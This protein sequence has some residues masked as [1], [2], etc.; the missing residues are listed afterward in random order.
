[1]GGNC[2]RGALGRQADG[3]AWLFKKNIKT[4]ETFK[5]EDDGRKVI[6]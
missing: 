5:E 4:S 6:S 2:R 3:E 1:M